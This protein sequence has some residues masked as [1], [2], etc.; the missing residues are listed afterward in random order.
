[1]RNTDR[2]ASILELESHP[3]MTRTAF[4]TSLPRVMQVV[5]IH[6]SGTLM[7]KL[8]LEKKNSKLF[9]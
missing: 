4:M 9:K 3:G 6:F 1:M 2:S 5:N 7:P 8:V